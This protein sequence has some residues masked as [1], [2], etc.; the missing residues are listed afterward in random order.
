MEVAFLRSEVEFHVEGNSSS[1]FA[2][3]AVVAEKNVTWESN[4]M[5]FEFVEHGN[6]QLRLYALA[7]GL[8]AGTWGVE[9]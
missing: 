6:T 8:G 9:S 5:V 1:S 4:L 3:G 2:G 7:V